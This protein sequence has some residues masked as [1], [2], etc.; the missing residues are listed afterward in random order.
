[1]PITKLRSSRRTTPRRVP[2]TLALTCTLYPG[3][4]QVILA[5]IKKLSA[6][7]PLIKQFDEAKASGALGRAALLLKTRNPS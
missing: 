3:R 2:C 6:N 1:M 7:K 5:Q 4:P